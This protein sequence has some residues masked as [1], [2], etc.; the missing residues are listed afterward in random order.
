[1][2]AR[3]SPSVH[4]APMLVIGLCL[5][6]PALADAPAGQYFQFD[7][8]DQ[9]IKDNFT[10]LRWRRFITGTA[11]S[12]TSAG[13][14]CANLTP[15]GTYRLPTVKELL[16]MVDEEPSGEYDDAL[17]QT[18]NKYLDDQAFPR[19]PV[20]LSYWSSTIDP[21]ESTRAY[22]VNFRSGLVKSDPTSGNAYYRCVTNEGP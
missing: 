17:L 18:I 22:V 10:K 8:N 5:A 15:V 12:H 6:A 14:Q 13:I 20:D 21:S 2:R 11:V 3:R 1:M 19:T 16:T 7:K 9:T 4:V